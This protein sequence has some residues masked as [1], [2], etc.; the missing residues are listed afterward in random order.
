MV[1]GTI[2]TYSRGSGQRPVGLAVSRS[3]EAEVLNEEPSVEMGTHR[4]RTILLSV[5]ILGYLCFLIVLA[6]LLKGLIRGIPQAAVYGAATILILGAA[7]Y[8]ACGTPI[9]GLPRAEVRRYFAP[10]LLGS[11]TIIGL[12]AVLGI[13]V[14]VMA[15]K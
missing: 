3:V 15:A 11:C 12:L 6:S 5:Q 13:A 14:M 10:Y 8:L 7:R 4:N 1:A 9:L 2:Q